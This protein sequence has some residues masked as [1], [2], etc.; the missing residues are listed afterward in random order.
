MAQ[1]G[2][3]DAHDAGL[4]WGDAAQQGPADA[5]DAGVVGRMQRKKD[6]LMPMMLALAW[7]IQC[8]K[9]QLMMMMIMMT[10]ARFAVHS[11]ER[12]G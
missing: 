1:E 9:C 7:W 10:M 3:A 2:P 11:A 5:Y 8:T 12:A 4:V 6:E